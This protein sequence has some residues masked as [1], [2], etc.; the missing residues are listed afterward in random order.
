MTF[1]FSLGVS[2]CAVSVPLSQRPANAQDLLYRWQHQADM[3]IL[4]ART[5]SLDLPYTDLSSHPDGL[6]DMVPGQL[7]PNGLEWAAP[8]HH[9]WG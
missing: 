9:L 4:L 5:A 8:C 1:Y 3:N 6:P 7:L 2:D